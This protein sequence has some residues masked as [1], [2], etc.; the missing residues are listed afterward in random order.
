MKVFKKNL[1]SI[2][3]SLSALAVKVEK[4]AAVIEE[5]ICSSKTCQENS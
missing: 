1:I 3:E 4:I 2:S 5:R